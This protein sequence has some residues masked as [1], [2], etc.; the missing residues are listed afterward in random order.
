MFRGYLVTEVL[1]TKFSCVRTTSE[2]LHARVAY[3]RNTREVLHVACKS[4]MSH[5]RGAH[6]HAWTFQGTG[7]GPI[8]S[9]LVEREC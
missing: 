5:A 2:V 1:H 6:A 9:F 4:F 3:V 8:D 7:S